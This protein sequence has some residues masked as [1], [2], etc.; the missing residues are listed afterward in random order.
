[1]QR[2]LK[3]AKNIAPAQLPRKGT[4]MKKLAIITVLAVL[5]ALTFSAVVYAE[6]VV[7]SERIRC[8]SKTCY[9]E[10]KFRVTSNSD[11]VLTTLYGGQDG[12]G[13]KELGRSSH[14]KTIYANR[15]LRDITDFSV[16]YP[17]PQPGKWAF[18][19][20]TEELGKEVASVGI[21]EHEVDATSRL[22][23]D[24]P[25]ACR[26]NSITGSKVRITFSIKMLFGT[27]VSDAVS[28]R[29]RETEYT[30]KREVELKP[31][32]AKAHY[33]LSIS[34]E[35]YRR[36]Y[37]GWRGKVTIVSPYGAGSEMVSFPATVRSCYIEC[38]NDSILPCGELT[39]K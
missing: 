37:M 19:L 11:D 30:A 1:M 39:G 14:S 5:V 38:A 25:N 8:D 7:P 31:H 28:V 16:Y 4:V 35:S 29:I 24:S 36:L 3:S 27:K 23:F 22:Q 32:P 33:Q 34:E 13:F 21:F 20:F 26:I 17:I 9:P 10:V 15:V 12:R 18:Q 2:A 6:K